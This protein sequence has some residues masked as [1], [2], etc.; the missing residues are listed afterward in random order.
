MHENQLSCG[1]NQESDVEWSPSD[2]RLSVLPT[3]L[4][5]TNPFLAIIAKYGVPIRQWTWFI[6]RYKDCL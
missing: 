4:F 6:N 1:K 2:L 5:I 3:A